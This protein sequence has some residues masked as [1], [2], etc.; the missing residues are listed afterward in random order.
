MNASRI[1][2]LSLG[3]LDNEDIEMINS[4]GNNCQNDSVGKIIA[5]AIKCGSLY[6]LNCEQDE[7]VNVAKS[8]KDIWHKRYGHLSFGNF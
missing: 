3:F 4:V 5:L 6:F 7:R 2:F 1:G 8:T